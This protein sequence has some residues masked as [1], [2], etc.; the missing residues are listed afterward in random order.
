MKKTILKIKGITQNKKGFTL[1]EVVVATAIVVIVS[2]ML[3]YAFMAA[4]NINKRSNEIKKENREIDYNIHAAVNEREVDLDKNLE[5]PVIK[6]GEPSQQLQVTENGIPRDF[7]MPMYV[8]TFE[9]GDRQ[10]LVFRNP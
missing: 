7:K 8:F 2:A 6:V 10:M 1:V 5:I 3:M 9:T 4:A